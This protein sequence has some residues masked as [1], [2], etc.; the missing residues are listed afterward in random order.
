VSPRFF[1]EVVAGLHLIFKSVGTVKNCQTT[2][3]VVPV[4]VRCGVV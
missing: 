1:L 4:S 2:V 3:L